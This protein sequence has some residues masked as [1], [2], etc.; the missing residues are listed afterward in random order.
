MASGAAPSK[1]RTAPV[2]TISSRPPASMKPP[3][4]TWKAGQPNGLLSFPASS[5]TSSDKI[6]HAQP[7]AYL[8]ALRS[9]HAA[10]LAEA[11][12]RSAM[13]V[14][15]SLRLPPERDFAPAVQHYLHQ[16]RR[17]LRVRLNRKS[18]VWGKGV[19]VSVETGG[20]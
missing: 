2:K 13:P 10:V 14:S 11:G 18:V 8:L 1:L 16:H 17:K 12:Q 15:N 3:I 6:R 9:D 19:S 7:Y 5:S 4:A 20:L